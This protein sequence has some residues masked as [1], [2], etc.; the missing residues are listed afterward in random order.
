MTRECFDGIVWNGRSVL[1]MRS[2]PGIFR[3]E[4][5]DFVNCLISVQGDDIVALKDIETV[6]TGGHI[7]G[8]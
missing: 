4:E 7:Y 2:V 6:N 5:V 8:E 3:V 1:T